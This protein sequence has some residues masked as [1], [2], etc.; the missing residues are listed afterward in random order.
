MTKFLNVKKYALNYPYMVF[1]ADSDNV[2]TKW[3]WG[4]WNDRNAANEAALEIGG[5]VWETAAIKDICEVD[6]FGW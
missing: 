2:L 6:E 3:F 4:A 1:R 5:E